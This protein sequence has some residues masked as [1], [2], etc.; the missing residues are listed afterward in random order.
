[1]ASSF[2][3]R[4]YEQQTTT[5]LSSVYIYLPGSRI[6][7]HKLHHLRISYS[8][9]SMQG[10]LLHTIGAW[11][12][13]SLIVCDEGIPQNANPRQHFRAGIQQVLQ[14]Y[15]MR[16]SVRTGFCR[17]IEFKEDDSPDE[18][19][20]DVV[21]RDDWADRFRYN[22]R[23]EPSPGDVKTQLFQAAVLGRT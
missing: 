20:I 19:G 2:C 8:V 18:R 12:G 13:C 11:C 4:A 16:D 1:M 3:V 22:L 23:E 7:R 17:I 15:S 9:F 5:R 21:L 6:H 10:H 14:D